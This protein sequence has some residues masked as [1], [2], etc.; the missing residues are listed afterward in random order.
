MPRPYSDVFLFDMSTGNAHQERE[1][2]QL[3]NEA[4]YIACLF[5]FVGVLIKFDKSKDAQGEI[6]SE[7][8]FIESLVY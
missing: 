6:I 1:H 4:L 2:D 5:F 3:G 7:R 8:V